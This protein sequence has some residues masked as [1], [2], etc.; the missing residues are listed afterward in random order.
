MRNMTAIISTEKLSPR[1]TAYTIEAPQVAAEALPGQLLLAHFEGTQGPLPYPVSDVGDGT[2]TFV[3]A[4]TTPAEG[5]AVLSDF[6]GPVGSTRVSDSK[7]RILCVAEGVGIAAMLPRLRELKGSGAYTIVVVGYDDK[8]GIYWQERIDELADELY[9]V[10]RDGS[11]GVKGP[12]QHV[13]K[14]ICES[15]A[16]LDR[17]LLITPLDTLK[18]S[19]KHTESR[20]LPA[21]VSLGAIL[22]HVRPVSDDDADFGVGLVSYDWQSANDIDGHE[23]N[24]DELT[25]RLG[26]PIK[27]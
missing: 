12:V 10:T 6:S 8:D 9:I 26:I 22:E 27:R 11:F 7:G 14:A 2:I 17:A 4:T 20:G 18:A 1:H 16:E 3:G 21:R 13:V 25:K 19:L 24:F 15:T 23:L 5:T